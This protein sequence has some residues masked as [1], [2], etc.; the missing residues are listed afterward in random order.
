ME[1]VGGHIDQKR[2]LQAE[3]FTVEGAGGHIGRMTLAAVGAVIYLLTKGMR[4]ITP[5]KNT[6]TS[7]MVKVL[8]TFKYPMPVGTGLL[9]KLCKL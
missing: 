2:S 9:P 1:G 5:E 3:G 8:F 6:T 4:R 7:N